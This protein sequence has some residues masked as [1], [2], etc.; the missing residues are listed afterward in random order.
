MV[1][2]VPGRAH[3][4]FPQP[5]E[6]GGHASGSRGADQQV[7]AELEVLLEELGIDSAL[8]HGGETFVRGEVGGFGSAEVEI[9][10]AEEPLVL[11]DMPLAELGVALGGCVGHALDAQLAR[12]IAEVACRG[13]DEDCGRIGAIDPQTIVRG[14]DRAAIGSH[15]QPGFVSDALPV[16]RVAVHDESARSIGLDGHVPRAREADRA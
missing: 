4:G 5:L 2:S 14:A 6:I 12:V 8:L 15:L 9:D 13:H 10:P 3:P 16:A 1:I 11:L 7:A